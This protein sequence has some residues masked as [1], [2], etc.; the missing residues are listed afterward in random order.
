[1]ENPNIR[2]LGLQ[3]LPRPKSHPWIIS[4]SK[5]SRNTAFQIVIYPTVIYLGSRALKDPVRSA[6]QRQ[7]T[8]MMPKMEYQTQINGHHG[9]IQ[10]I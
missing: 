6:H 10:S 9:R 2:K 7:L 4:H 1:M 5:K 3:I 8:G